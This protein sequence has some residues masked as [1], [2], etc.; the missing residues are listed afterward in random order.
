MKNEKLMEMQDV[1]KFA[2][3]IHEKTSCTTSE[4]LNWIS[5]VLTVLSEPAHGAVDI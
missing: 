1:N 5:F 2:D 3:A 4:S